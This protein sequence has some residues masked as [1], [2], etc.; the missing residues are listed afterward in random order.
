MAVRDSVSDTERRL[1]AGPRDLFLAGFTLVELLVVIAIIATI[2]YPTPAALY[3]ATPRNPPR[4]RGKSLF[5]CPAARRPPFQ[6][7]VGRAYFMY[8][9]NAG[10]CINK[11]TRTGPLPLSNTKLGAIARAAE[12]IYGAEVDGV[13]P[14]GGIAQAK[15]TSRHAPARHNWR[16]QF[17]MCDGNA[18]ALRRQDFIRTAAEANSASEEWKVSRA[19]CG[20]PTATTRN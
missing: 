4:P 8:G 5:S 9:M 1:C 16:G 13:F 2:D 10:L 14:Q 20:Y 15:V 17:A 18:R 12:T 6:P 11:S 7:S 19:V 3:T